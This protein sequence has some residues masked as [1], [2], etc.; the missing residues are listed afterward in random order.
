MFFGS[1]RKI[2]SSPARL[3][4]ALGLLAPLSVEAA[5]VTLNNGDQVTG[6]LEQLSNGILTIKSPIFGEVKIPWGNVARLVS[7]ENVRVQLN[8][9]ALVQ[10]PMALNANGTVAIHEQPAQPPQTLPRD[11]ISALNPPVIDESFK[12]SGK[13]DLGG[14]FDRGNSTDDQWHTSG[15]LTARR[16]KDRYTL[17]W[18]LN[19]AKSAGVTTTSNRRVVGQY[20]RFLDPKNYVFLNAKAERDE[21]ADLNLRTAAGGGYG[22][23]FID[24]AVTKLSGQVGLAYVHEDYDV[25]PD[26]SFPSLSLGFK[27]DQKFFEQKLDFFNNLDMDT[28]LRDTQNILLHNRM[29]FRIPIA[30]GINLSTQFNLDFDNEPA[31]GK[32]KTDTSLI[33][34]VGYAF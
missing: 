11:Q 27:Y 2:P 22:R 23:Q 13:I 4:L 20:D 8:N 24:S 7:N 16:P 10:G 15:Q 25:S 6:T 14:A 32:K 28:S 9:G 30:H 1:K 18:E 31:M 34:S 19:E 12:Y 3:L 21:M 5:T 29:G 17:N 26:Q 33:F